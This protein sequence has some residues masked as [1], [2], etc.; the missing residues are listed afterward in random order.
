MN[1]QTDKLGFLVYSL[2]LIYSSVYVLPAPNST[3]GSTNQK[4]DV[5]APLLLARFFLKTSE[6]CFRPCAPTRALILFQASL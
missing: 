6:F 1:K 4:S 5:T 3:E 2:Y